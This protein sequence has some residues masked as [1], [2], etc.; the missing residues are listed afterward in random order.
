[1]RIAL[2]YG[3]RSGEHEVSI[4]SARSI[5]SELKKTHQV[6]PIFIDKEGLWWRVN[7]LDQLP[8]TK[9]KLADRVFV[10]PGFTEP[11]LHTVS[12]QLKIDIVFPV[13]HGT[14][15]EDGII[16]GLL[17]SAGI[18]YVG[19]NVAAS[20][21]GMDKVI[22]KAL[23]AQNHLPVGAYTWFLR[24]RWR[25]HPDDCMAAV[26]QA[27]PYPVFVKPA[28]MGSSVGISKAR[29]R[30]ELRL[31]LEDAARYDRKLLVEQGLDAREIE[32]SVLGNEQP[33]ASLP[34][35]IVPKREFYDY[36]AK[37]IE[38]STELHVPAK[39]DAAQVRE[40]QTLAIGAFQ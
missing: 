3:G 18:P 34:G 27:F 4:R 11:A 15:G 5:F 24:S 39:L 22:M 25:G 19:A 7:S 13:L 6:Y 23:F 37:Y 31:G 1:M 32:C 29:N 8:A 12:A 21:A 38:E 28:N 30:Q 26:E 2:L 36:V 17:E 9:D 16:Q 35:E 10:L 33:R 14:H 40:A 20:A